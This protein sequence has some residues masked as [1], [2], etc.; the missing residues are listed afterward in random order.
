MENKLKKIMFLLLICTV[1]IISCSGGQK[2]DNTVKLGAIIPLTGPIA[3][4]GELMK[5]G[6][7]LAKEEINSQSAQTGLK[8]EI[9]YGDNK[10]LP[11]DAV[12]QIQKQISI[13]KIKYFIVSPTPACMAVA[14][15]VD[16]EKVIM[17]AGSLHPYITEQSKYIYRTTVSNAE[18]DELIA[19]YAEKNNFK[20]IAVI[21]VEDDFGQSSLQYFKKVFKGNVI[22][23]EPYSE[24]DS[25]F[26]EQILKIKKANPDAILTYGYGTAYPIILKQMVEYNINLPILSDT[27]MANPPVQAV[28]NQLPQAFTDRIVFAAPLF[29]KRFVEL[30]REKFSKE[31]NLNY[32]FT[33]DFVKIVSQAIE[34]NGNDVEKVRQYINNL[35]D[36]TG[37]AEKI[38][39]LPNRDTRSAVRLM[40]MKNGKIV[41][42]DS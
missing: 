12:S 22:A 33:Y 24:K 29:S 19:R 36:F 42:L 17:F 25:D 5:S 40:K 23:E 14:P 9:V 34:K 41:E 18:V 8:V 21:Y 38:T 32:A 39:F 11:K 26:R 20:N 3:P 31:A 27:S 10:G 30:T 35:K 28:I 4:I 13:D 15:I 37:A 1:M 2:K 6:L 16:K 7:E